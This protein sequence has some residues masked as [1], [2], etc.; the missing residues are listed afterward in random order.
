MLRCQ[1]AFLRQ[2]P[3]MDSDEKSRD[4]SESDDGGP[5]GS[6]SVLLPKP[7]AIPS[8]DL[9]CGAAQVI[10]VHRGQPY[11]LLETRNGRLMLQK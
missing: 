6:E 11:R 7:R 1:A 5:A 8:E 2:W 4:T 3:E 10:I 9:L